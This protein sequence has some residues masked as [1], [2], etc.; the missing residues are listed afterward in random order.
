MCRGARLQAADY[1]EEL[2]PMQGL[3]FAEAGNKGFGAGD[4]EEILVRSGRDGGLDLPLELFNA[5]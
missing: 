2:A 4:Y 3:R 1:A 5:Q